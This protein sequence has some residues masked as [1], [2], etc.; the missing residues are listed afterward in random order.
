MQES[1]TFDR[2]HVTC[3]WFNL[4]KIEVI[5]IGFRK[6]DMLGLR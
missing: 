1:V 6:L 3:V 2:W 4:V 5:L